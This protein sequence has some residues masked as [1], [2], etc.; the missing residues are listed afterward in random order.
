MSDT[1]LARYNLDETNDFYSTAADEE[2]NA[3][4]RANT[5]E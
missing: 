4:E 2:N 3:I 5:R 1:D